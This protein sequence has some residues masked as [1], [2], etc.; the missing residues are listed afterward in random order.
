MWDNVNQ[1]LKHQQCKYQPNTPS[2]SPRN[3][4]NKNNNIHGYGANKQQLK[5]HLYD[6][7]ILNYF[8]NDHQGLC[9]LHKND[10]STIIAHSVT[11]RW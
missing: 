8:I 10:I 1:I 7:D 3:I 2:S 6:T 5:G 11:H 9:L 4:L